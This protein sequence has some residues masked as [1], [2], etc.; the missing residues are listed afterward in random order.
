MGKAFGSDSS[1]IG[2]YTASRVDYVDRILM[3]F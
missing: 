3:K 2:G 1:G